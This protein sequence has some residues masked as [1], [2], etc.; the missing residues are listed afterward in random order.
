MIQVPMHAHLKKDLDHASRAEF[1]N[2]RKNMRK[3]TRMGVLSLLFALL[4]MS[5]SL[6]P[7]VSAQVDANRQPVSNVGTV[8]HF[9]PPELKIIENNDSSTI[10]LS[11]DVLISLRNDRPEKT[12]ALEIKNL[13]TGVTSRLT[14]E[15]YE[16][17]GKYYTTMH[18]G[19]ASSSFVT[20]FDPF[21]PLSEQKNQT[22]A[23]QEKTGVSPNSAR[24]LYWWD[25]V[26]FAQGYG[27]KYPHPDYAS[28][29][30]NAWD[31]AYVQGSQLKHTH[32]S[33]SLSAAYGG[34]PALVTLLA[35]GGY[36]N[37]LS[38][39][40]QTIGGSMGGAGSWLTMTY[41]FDEQSCIWGWQSNNW[42]F[43][44]TWIAP[45]IVYAP[46]YIRIGPFTVWDDLGIG[47]P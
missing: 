28:Y 19:Q 7:A 4:L 30:I 15:Y 45:F 13:T 37:G 2:R 18:E 39:L 25:G 44:S 1:L 3:K 41:L 47:N 31:N 27:I 21:R 24:T 46:Y 42:H 8:V 26:L 6:M 38:L 11:G 10:V 14:F 43:R 29:G 36:G 17:D 40:G 9:T 20:P 22:S 33:Q 35:I 32:Y 16:K 5:M 23:V 12:A 34:L